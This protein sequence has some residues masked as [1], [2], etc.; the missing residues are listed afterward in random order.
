MTPC[1]LLQNDHQTPFGE[2]QLQTESVYQCATIATTFDAAETLAKQHLAG[3]L[4]TVLY[5][6]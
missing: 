5:E 2:P 3:R 6:L 1:G 4:K